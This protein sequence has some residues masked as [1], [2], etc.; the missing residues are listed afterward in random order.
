MTTTRVCSR[1]VSAWRFWNR[2]RVPGVLPRLEPLDPRQLLSGVSIGGNEVSIDG[3]DGDDA[4][5][6]VIITTR[7]P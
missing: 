3:T 6:I 7:G 5:R 4:I 2:L 1:C